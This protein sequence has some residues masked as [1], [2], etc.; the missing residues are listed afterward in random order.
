MNKNSLIPRYVY[1][2]LGTK[3]GMECPAKRYIILTTFSLTFTK[4]YERVSCVYG[5]E[6]ENLMIDLAD[7]LLYAIRLNIRR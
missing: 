7:L 3:G 1:D 5:V 4:H 2:L 6:R